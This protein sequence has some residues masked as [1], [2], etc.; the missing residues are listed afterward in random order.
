MKEKRKKLE[1]VKASIKFFIKV[2]KPRRLFLLIILL[3]ANTFGWFIFST[4]VSTSLDV[5]VKAWD[6]L[7]EA[8]N[9]PIT[10][11]VY[12]TIDELY[13]GMTPFNYT[14]GATNRGEMSATVHYTILEF[15]LFGTTYYTV[16]GRQE[17]EEEVQYGD[18]TSAQFEQALLDNDLFPFTISMGFDNETM[19]PVVGTSNFSLNLT[20]PYESGHDEQDTLLGQQAYTFKQEHPTDPSISFKIKL[21]IQ[22][23]LPEESPGAS[24]SASPE[25]P[26]EEPDEP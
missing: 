20:W 7:F 11:Y 25:T 14:L 8:G 23:I 5:H 1:N 2:A 6:V 13:P 18:L 26:P 4:K 17:A 19:R 22:Q 24:P 9:S 3:M 12:L 15:K 16:E 21:Q 10:D